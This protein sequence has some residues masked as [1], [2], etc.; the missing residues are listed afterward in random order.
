L[1]IFG[2]LCRAELCSLKELFL[3]SIET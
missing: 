2:N 3:G 1:S